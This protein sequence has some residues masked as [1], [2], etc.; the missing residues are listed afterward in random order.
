MSVTFDD[1]LLAYIALIVFGYIDQMRIK[2][3]D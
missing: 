2:A 3:M 1:F